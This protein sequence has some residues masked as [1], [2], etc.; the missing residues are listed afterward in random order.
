[1]KN[2]ERTQRIEKETKRALSEIFHFDQ[3]L[4]LPGFCSVVHVDMSPD[5]K[6]A[7]VYLR[8]VNEKLSQKEVEEVLEKNRPSLQKQLAEKLSARFT[9]VIRFYT[10]VVSGSE[11][12]DVER[13]LA[14]LG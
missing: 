9:P 11:I 8:V 12:D 10:K 7:K 14:K 13:L 1:M 6:A 3:K 2:V 4:S 5:L